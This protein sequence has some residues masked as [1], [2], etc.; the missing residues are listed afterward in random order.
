[1]RAR[2]LGQDGAPAVQGAFLPILALPFPP[3]LLDAA[4]EFRLLLLEERSDFL[5]VSQDR[6]GRPLPAVGRHLVDLCFASL[7][8]GTAANS[9]EDRFRRLA[10]RNEG[11]A[12]T[13]RRAPSASGAVL[14]ATEHLFFGAPGLSATW[15]PR[16]TVS[17]V[18]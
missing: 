17:P 7:E 4:N 13:A 1:M 12:E 14:A 5:R 11:D 18:S 2:W 9:S 6:P 16:P 8:H 3:P 10:G 15:Q